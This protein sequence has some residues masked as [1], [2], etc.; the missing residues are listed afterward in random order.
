[1]VLGLCQPCKSTEPASY[2]RYL[3]I[4]QQHNLFAVQGVKKQSCLLLVS[5]MKTS[6]RNKTPQKLSNRSVQN[7]VSFLLEWT[8][9]APLWSQEATGLCVRQEQ[10]SGSLRNGVQN[11]EFSVIV[12]LT[13]KAVFVPFQM[14]IAVTCS[15]KLNKATVSKVC[16]A[17]FSHGQPPVLLNLPLVHYRFLQQIWMDCLLIATNFFWVLG[18]SMGKINTICTLVVPIMLWVLGIHTLITTMA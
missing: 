12:V 16:A 4:K 11:E 17:P 13:Y 8:C 15:S 14:A 18:I 1:M 10:C 6:P 2:P 3:N 7:K 5:T 9:T